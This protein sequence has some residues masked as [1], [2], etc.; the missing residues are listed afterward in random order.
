M[1]YSN[2]Y[3]VFHGVVGVNETDKLKVTI[4]AVFKASLVV[5]HVHECEW[6]ARLYR[7]FAGD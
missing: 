3:A 2:F 5:P 7:W 4:G 6:L 1:Y